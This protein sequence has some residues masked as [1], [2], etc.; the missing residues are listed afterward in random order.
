M[1]PHVQST[2]GGGSPLLNVRVA[3]VGFLLLLDD[4]AVVVSPPSG[5]V[6]PVGR[7]P[8]AR[9]AP[10]GRPAPAW[11]RH[12]HAAHQ[13]PTPRKRGAVAA[14]VAPTVAPAPTASVAP[15]ATTGPSAATLAPV[16]TPAAP[17]AFSSR[18]AEPYGFKWEVG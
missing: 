16:E 13:D 6:P 10:T 2:G 17:A 18:A 7:V 3:V 14:A 9:R 15:V 1:S 12:I 4:N 5:P 8:A 11:G